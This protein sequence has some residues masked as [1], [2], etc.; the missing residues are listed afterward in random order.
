MMN[1]DRKKCCEL[2]PLFTI[3]FGPN[4]VKFAAAVDELPID[5]GDWQLASHVP[6]FA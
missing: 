1:L 6:V 2:D 3:S 4:G 5:K